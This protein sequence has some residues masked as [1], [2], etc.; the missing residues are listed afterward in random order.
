MPL[1]DYEHEMLTDTTDMK[2]VRGRNEDTT[3]SIVRA[4]CDENNF[5][6]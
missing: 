5:L 3:R 1:F 2:N 6:P 4:S